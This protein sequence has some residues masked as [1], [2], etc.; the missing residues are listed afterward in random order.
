[1]RTAFG[2]SFDVPAGYL[3]TASIGIPATR[4]GEAVAEA[5]DEWRSGRS[6]PPQYDVHVEA[7][8]RGWARLAGV[9][10]ENVASGASVS[11]LVGLVAASVPDGTRVVT[12]GNEFTS[13]TFPFA[14]QEK[15]GVTVT[16]VPLDRLAGSLD[17]ADLV[18][19]SVAQSADGA[20]VDLAALRDSGKPVLLDATQALGWLPL[21]LA[22]AHYVVGGSYKW[23]TAPRGAAW[24]AVHPDAAQ[25]VPHLAN[26]YAAEDPWDGVYGLPLRLASGAR[27]LDLSPVWFAQVG[28]A[29]AVEWLGGLDL[30][31]VRD[32]C[33]GL[34][35]RLRAHLDLPPAGSAITAVDLTPAQADRLAA[36]GVV[37]S[38]RAGRTRLS[39]HLYN[40]EDDLDL[41]LS[42]LA[43]TR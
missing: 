18:A 43:T 9:A 6:R 37:S 5:V 34:A 2:E 29:A 27:G 25:P 28:A 41:V 32:H 35:D 39:W 24:L 4:V 10:A 12:A 15:R 22:W 11:Q 40:T 21:D 16:E 14:A 3:N 17:E 20:L 19:V 36:A 26:W 7:A 30:T 33:A 38:V 1:M 13:V 8:R 23:L 42:A 31:D